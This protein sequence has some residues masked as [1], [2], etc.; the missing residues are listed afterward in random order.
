MPTIA[1]APAPGHA[2]GHGRTHIHTVYVLGFLPPLLHRFIA[3][4]RNPYHKGTFGETVEEMAEFV[5][6][7]SKEVDAVVV[8]VSMLAKKEVSDEEWLER[9]KKLL[10]LTPG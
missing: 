5:N 8:L 1:H 3:I 6:K 7:M 4:N 9:C 2:P 10:A